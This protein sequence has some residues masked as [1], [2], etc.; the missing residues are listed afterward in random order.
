MNEQGEDREAIH[1]L[2]LAK[3][4]FR[5]NYPGLKPKD[6]RLMAL[7]DLYDEVDSET[8]KKDAVTEDGKLSAIIRRE[9]VRNRIDMRHTEVDGYGSAMQEADRQL[10]LL[11]E[12][13]AKADPHSKLDPTIKAAS[14]M[15]QLAEKL[16]T[17]PPS[18][19]PVK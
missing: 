1:A 17:K 11:S 8:S 3:R 15:M 18:P 16:A 6:P 13:E 7:W 14:T 9:Q 2:D 12:A 5:D 19:S 10:V 4:E